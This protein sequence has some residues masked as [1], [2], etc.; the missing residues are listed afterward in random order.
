MN[1]THQFEHS[2]HLAN[3]GGISLITHLRA[4]LLLERDYGN[5]ITMGNLAIDLGVCSATMTGIADVLER[6]NL[7]KRIPNPYNRRSIL[8]EITHEGIEFLK[9]ITKP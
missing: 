1:F 4:L 5:D 3:E 2:L 9:T 6:M 7:I 8:L